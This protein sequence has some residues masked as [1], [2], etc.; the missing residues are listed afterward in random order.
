VTKKIKWRKIL[1]G[2]FTFKRLLI[3]I[4]EI[5]IVLA[6]FIYFR[7]DSLI[8]LSP[9]SSYQDDET[10][11]KLTSNETQISALYLPNEEAEFTIIY[12]HGNAEDLGL[13]R[14][15]LKELSALGF[16]V[17]GY[18]YQ[19]Y[20]TSGGKP[21]EKNSYADI[22]ASYQYLTDE[23]N[24][25]P[26]KI[27]LYGRSVGAG[28]TIELAQKYPS[29]GLILESSFA[30]AFRARINI[31]LLPFDKFDNLRKIKNIQIPVMYIHGVEDQ[32]IPLWHSQRLMQ[33]T[34]KVESYLW[35]EGAGHNDLYFKAG[36][37][38]K[39]RIL[40]FSEELN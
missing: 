29:A 26:K 3:S 35:V 1:I 21:T 38:I 27:I 8:F 40:K 4:L 30:S 9:P 6:L 7:A 11:V 25:D 33:I 28:A 37:K 14:P 19:G 34:P 17:L 31:P 23:I 39:Q 10:I 15:W 18:D 32:I 24:I 22:E 16:N 5:Y 20:G 36:E 13:V 2:E 12:S